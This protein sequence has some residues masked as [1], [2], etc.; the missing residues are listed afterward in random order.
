[1]YDIYWYTTKRCDYASNEVDT[2]KAD[3]DSMDYQQTLEGRTRTEDVTRTEGVST[4]TEEY[5]KKVKQT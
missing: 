3:N 2:E 4:V 5:E 1:M